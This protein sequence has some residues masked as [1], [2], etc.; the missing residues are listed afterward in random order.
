MSRNLLH[1]LIF[2]CGNIAGGFD[3]GRSADSLMYDGLLLLRQAFSFR[4]K[5]I[6]KKA[7][8]FF[9]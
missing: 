9:R 6:V 2:D 8:F 5:E 1:S 4:T 3:Q 7:F